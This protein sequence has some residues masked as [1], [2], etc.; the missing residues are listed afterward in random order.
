MDIDGDTGLLEGKRHDDVRRLAPDSR[1]CEKI[2]QIMGHLALKT[3][4]KQGR[5]VMEG[6]G[7][8]SVERDGI[9]PL[10]DLPDRNLEHRLRVVGDFEKP[11]TG[12]GRRLI[13]GSQTENAGNQ[14]RIR[15]MSVVPYSWNGPIADLLPEDSENLR[16]VLVFHEPLPIDTR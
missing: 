3:I 15:C 14:H 5:N 7:F 10:L 4:D 13:L 2:V 8:D 1:K 9:D 16:D 6:L 11:L 12:P